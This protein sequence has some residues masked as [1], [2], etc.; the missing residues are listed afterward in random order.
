MAD[1]TFKK[2]GPGT[3]KFGPTASAKEFG[4]ACKK[5]EVNPEM[6]DEDQTDLLSGDAYKPEGS[7]SGS[8]SGV[9]LQ[10]YDADSLL[11]WTWENNGATLDFEFMPATS[12]KMKVK[13]K[14]QI[15][16]MKVGGDVGKVNDSDF[17]FPLV[18]SSLP[19]MTLT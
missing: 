5:V 9:L 13:G 16:A 19:T 10:D 3:L 4:I 1:K 11:A 7:I 8:V 14:C 6:K 12:G 15:R 2:L 17:S 18:G